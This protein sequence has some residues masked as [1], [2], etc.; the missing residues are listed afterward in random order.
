MLEAI[1][2]RVKVASLML[3]FLAPVA[4]SA[5]SKSL[6]RWMET[7]QRFEALPNPQLSHSSASGMERPGNG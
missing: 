4:V 6:D 7:N 1:L 5:W 2:S 3:L